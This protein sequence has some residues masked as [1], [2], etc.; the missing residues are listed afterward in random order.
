[1]ALVIASMYF[2]RSVV[3]ADT[4]VMSDVGL[5]L[6]PVWHAINKYRLIVRI[7]YR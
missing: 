5:G 3:V 2:H 1:L 4:D 7:G 6:L